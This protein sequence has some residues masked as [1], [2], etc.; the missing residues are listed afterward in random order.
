LGN[1]VDRCVASRTT[2]RDE[3]VIA[4]TWLGLVVEL[5]VLAGETFSGAAKKVAIIVSGALAFRGCTRELA[6]DDSAGHI[7]VGCVDSGVAILAKGNVGRVVGRVGRAVRSTQENS[8]IFISQSA[9]V[10]VED[11][12]SGAAVADLGVE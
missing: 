6:A 7:L 2:A 3:Q 12:R 4:S 9:C 1:N 11:Y 10:G 8:S 5:I